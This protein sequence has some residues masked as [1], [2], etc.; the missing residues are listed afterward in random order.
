MSVKR[1]LEIELEK[2]EGFRNPKLWLEQYMTPPSLAAELAINASLID[3]KC[4]VIDLGSGTGMLSIAFELVGFRCIGVEIDPN[5]I[6]IAR[7]NAKRVGVN[8]NFVLC[9]VKMLNVKR[10][11]MVVMNPPFGIQRRHADRIF[12]NKAFEVGNVIYS[13]H[14]A[15]SEEFIE[16]LCEKKDFKITHLW[17]YLIPLKR[18]YKF[19]EKE[20]KRIA[21]E[22]YRMERR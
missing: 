4:N 13:I 15:G 3:N 20:F 17:K 16:K 14:S 12:L 8:P 22:V 10:K 6:S 21:V 18:T 19:H 7:L 11:C 2:L 1:S 5:A 9:D